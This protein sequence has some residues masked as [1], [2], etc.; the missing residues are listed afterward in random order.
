MRGSTVKMLRRNAGQVTPAQWRAMKRNYTSL[1]HTWKAEL[2][3]NDGERKAAARERA[4][5]EASR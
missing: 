2:R 3:E 4:R 1:P 5:I